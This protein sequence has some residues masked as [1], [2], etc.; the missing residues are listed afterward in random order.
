MPYSRGQV[1]VF[2]RSI[3]EIS[4]GDCAELHHTI[5]QDDVDT[6]SSLTGDFNPLHVD[7]EYAK[8]S[9]YQKPVVHGMLSASFISTMIG[10]SLPGSGA[11]WTSQTLEFLLPA[12]VGDTITVKSVVV[13]KSESV[14][15]IVLETTITNQLKQELVKGRSSVKILEIKGKPMNT[16][17]DEHRTVLVVG[18]SKGIGAAIVKRLAE[19]GHRVAFT[20]NS[21]KSA[22]EALAHDMQTA[23]RHV[24][25]VKYDALKTGDLEP[26]QQAIP[27]AFG[28]VHDVIY[29]AAPLPI[30]KALADTAWEDFKLQLDTQVGGAFHCVRSF[31]PHMVERKDGSFTFIGSIYAEGLPPTQQAAYVT[32]KAA[33]SA[34]ARSMAVELGPLGI[35]VNVIAPGMTETDMIASLPEKTKLLAKMQTPLRR[36]ASPEHIARVAEFLVGPGGAHIS[37]ETIKV[38]GGI[39]M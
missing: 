36:L 32:A 15:T 10:T 37:G 1:S 7:K 13:Q 28:K 2:S 9:S 20:Y 8:N 35:R 4:V 12:F 21:S 25:P 11:L 17:Q 39:S 5:T 16:P 24:V 26:L 29:C 6:F 31:V 34:F 19:Q 18:G 23:D 3:G 33:L 14:R 22:A 27:Q 38:C 30:P